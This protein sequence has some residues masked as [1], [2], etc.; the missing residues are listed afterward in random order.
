MLIILNRMHNLNKHITYYKEKSKIVID[1][2]NQ[3]ND[4]LIMLVKDDQDRILGTISDGDIRRGI[5]RGLSL[6]DEIINFINQ[7]FYFL[8]DK[9]DYKKIKK[10][11]EK[12]CNLIPILK[13]DNTLLDILTLNTKKVN[14]LPI[15]AIIMAG[16]KGK[17]LFP[18]TENCPKPLLKIKNKHVID[19]TIELLSKYGINDLNF[20]LNYKHQ[21]FLKYFSKIKTK[22]N[23]INHVI[24]NK[25][26]GTIGGVKLFN[27]FFHENILLIN[28][29]IITEI[30]LEDFFDF[31]Q[32]N[33][34][35]LTIATRYFNQNIPFAVIE[36]NN[37]RVISLKEKP[38]V[39]H[40]IN[41]GIYLLK[42]ELIEN[43]PANKFYDATDFIEDLIHQNKNLK[44]YTFH[45]QWID[46]GTVK[47]FNLMND[48]TN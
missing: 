48:E 4:S 43:I 2:I 9:Y 13:K 32:K 26:L 17:R 42:K 10:I 44:T 35:D 3:L 21:M 12:G 29:D 8:R 18:L 14:S 45:D 31:H 40:K 34:A 23:I 22:H 46:I 41:A 1:K 38:V 28:A 11:R 39:S 5:V 19:F 27:H 6:D 16:G 20:C 24:E 47:D 36:E 15:S 33:N 7:K 30:K 37:G 25:E